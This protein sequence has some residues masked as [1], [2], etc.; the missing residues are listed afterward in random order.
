M[1]ILFV[2]SG[3]SHYQIVPFIKNQ[4]DSLIKQGY[5][6]DFYP[7]VGKGIFGYYKNIRR[8]KDHIAKN[9]YDAIHAHYSLIGLVAL[10]SFSRK[11]IVLSLM[12]SDTYGDYDINGKRIPKSYIPMLITQM[13][14]PFVNAIIVKS[15]NLYKYVYR[16]KITSLIPNGVNF[17]RFHPMDQKECRKK[18]SLPIDK[19]IILFLANAN[20]PRKNYQLLH[21]AEP[22]IKCNNTKII[23]PFPIENKDF[24]LYLNACDVF[25]LTSYNEGSPNVI[26]EAMACNCPIVATD[27]GDVKEVISGV[28]GCFLATFMENDL[29]NK[30]DRALNITGRTG[31]RKHIDRLRDDKVAQKLIK[32]YNS[33]V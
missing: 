31:G 14:Q 11:P 15:E 16:P 26:K 2:S 20:D 6:V 9:N 4:G 5:E 13:I 24:P 27:V 32:I 23:N 33:L 25:V 8:L 1:K 18:L 30:I 7:V 28:E 17:N 3:N 12:G 29:A 21:K 10:L 19:K 22:L